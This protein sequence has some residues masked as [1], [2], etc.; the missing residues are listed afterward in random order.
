MRVHLAVDPRVGLPR[1]FGYVQYA[2]PEDAD[3]ACKSLHGGKLDGNVMQ[4]TLSYDVLPEEVSGGPRVERGGAT[5]PFREDSREERRDRS[6][7]RD[8]KGGRGGGGGGRR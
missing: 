1:G 5:M 6:R 3:E 7:S 4:V 2:T 8:R